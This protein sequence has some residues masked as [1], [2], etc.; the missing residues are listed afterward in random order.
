MKKGIHIVYR[1]KKKSTCQ[2]CT[3]SKSEF[4]IFLTVVKNH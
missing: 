3:T 4:A 2:K 1:K